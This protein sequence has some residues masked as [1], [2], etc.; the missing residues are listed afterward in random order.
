MQTDNAMALP[1]YFNP[2]HFK[3]GQRV[4]YSGFPGVILRHYSEGMW[5]VRIKSG[6]VCVSGADI[7]ELSDVHETFTSRE[8]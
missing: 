4:A 5:E 7:R 6:D 2:D 8:D 1:A 3:P